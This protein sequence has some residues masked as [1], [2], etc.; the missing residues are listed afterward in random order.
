MKKGF[1]FLL[2]F[3]ILISDQITKYLV[4]INFYEGETL[5]VT[6]KYLWLTY[7]EN[8]G[9]AFSIS[10]GNVIT[11]RIIF[12][13]VT[14][15]AVVLVI[16]LLIKS[17]HFLEKLGFSLVL[18]GAT[19][20]LIDRV[21]KGSVTDFINC[22]FPDFIMLRWPIFNIADSSLVVAIV[23]LSVYYVFFDK[24]LQDKEIKI[25][26]QDKGQE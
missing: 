1:W 9:A 4:R 25:E 10:L 16:I 23:I 3:L 24:K 2:S 6:P 20:N 17:K 13:L 21:Y 14:L 22:D 8:T 7:V 19:G 15:A 26:K 18:A 12:S 5:K 11:N